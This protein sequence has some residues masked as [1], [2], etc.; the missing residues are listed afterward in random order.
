MEYV[1]VALVGGWTTTIY[2]FV[3]YI[4][5]RDTKEQHLLNR[6]QSPEIAVMETQEVI[7]A[8]VYYTGEEAE[9]GARAD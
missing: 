6:I 5:T 4:R 1:A 7:P 3:R 9:D 2:F 8:T